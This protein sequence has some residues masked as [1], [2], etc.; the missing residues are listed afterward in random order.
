MDVLG[1]RS[2]VALGNHELLP[3]LDELD[4]EIIRL[5]GLRLQVVARME[6]TGYAQELGARD[7]VDLL[8]FRHRRDR[9]EVWRDVRLARALPRYAAV[10]AALADGIK[11]GSTQA[12]DSDG[13][14]GGSSQDGDSDGTFRAMQT[15]HAAAIVSELERVRTRVPVEDL[16]VAENQLVLLAAHLAPGELRAAAKQLCNLLDSDGPEPEEQR[17]YDRES[18][19]LTTA[20]N[21]VKFKGYLANEN[22]EL[23]RAVIHAGARP[24]KTA[25]GELDPRARDKRQA[26]ALSTALTVAANTWDTNANAR[27]T[28]AKTWHT[29][30]NGRDTTTNAWGAKDTGIRTPGAPVP[31][32]GAKANITVTID[33]DD[34]RSATANATGQTAYG[35]ELSATTI[36]RLACDANVIPLVLGSNSEP[37]DVGRRERL[38]TKSIRRALNARDRGC[39][40]CAAPPLRCDAHHLISWLDG[41]A[42]TVDNLALLCRRHHVDLHAGRWHVTITNGIPNVTR[43]NWA[44]PPG[45]GRPRRRPVN[46]PSWTTPPGADQLR[47]NRR[48]TSPEAEGGRP[49]RRPT[50]R[51]KVPTPVLSGT[52][53][54][55]PD[56][57][58]LNQAGVRT[59]H[60]EGIPATPP[61]PDPWSHPDPPVPTTPPSPD[62]SGH[63]D[64]SVPATPSAPDP[65]SHLVPPVPRASRW[66]AD[67]ATLT[68]AVRFAVW[69]H[70]TR[71]EPATGPPSFATI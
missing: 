5:Q 43:P 59:H 1:G 30:A 10:D 31:G 61:A 57:H 56:Q 17:A 53:P 27:D 60:P 35:D 25:D 70:R 21:G 24:H 19:T 50:E 7:T 51:D 29:N 39:V 49:R 9:S 55:R 8:A 67:E 28:T 37:L 64:P 26:D 40:V 6:E 45:P 3:V 16:D 2:V 15:A 47:G 54:A 42:T 71:T 11:V 62:P 65:W 4:A 44:T 69:G 13:I 66:K 38:V 33:L 20:D 63:L 41:G 46:R 58:A 23:L 68:A 12:S 36:R 22:A 34:L 14:E 18:L 52:T 32:Y 48:I